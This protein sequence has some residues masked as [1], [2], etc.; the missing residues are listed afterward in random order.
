MKDLDLRMMLKVVVF[1]APLGPSKAK[2]VSFPTPMLTS[3]TTLFPLKDFET[4]MTRRRSSDTAT[5]SAAAITS[6]F[7]DDAVPVSEVVLWRA[8]K[9]LLVWDPESTHTRVIRR[10]DAETNK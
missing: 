10:T 7:D 1:P 8:R 6:S 4:L 5:D 2:T 3:S 9:R